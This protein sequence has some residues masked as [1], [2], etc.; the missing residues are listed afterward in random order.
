MPTTSPVTLLI[1]MDRLIISP[2]TESLMQYQAEMKYTFF[3][4]IDITQTS[5]IADASPW[6][7]TSSKLINLAISHF[8]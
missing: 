1:G 7:V 8:R 6:Q 2:R 4:V 5:H 3:I